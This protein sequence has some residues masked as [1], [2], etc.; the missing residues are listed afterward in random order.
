MHFYV[1]ARLVR[2]VH[3]PPA[4]YRGLTAVFVVLF[5][6]VP[7]AFYLG[8]ALPPHR[9]A[10]LVGA[11]YTWIGVL[12]VLLVLCAT[13]DAVQ[14]VARVVRWVGD[15]KPP[16]DPERRIALARLVGGGIAL[17]GGSATG[18]GL[19]SGLAPV[20]VREVRV[21]LKAF[22]TALRGMT[23]VQ[24]SDM[25]LGP[26]L[27]RR[28]VERVVAQVNALEP[29]VIAITGDLV[30]GS[31]EK[32]REV[33]APLTKL[34]AKHG[35]YFV[36]G[37]HEYYSGAVEWCD[38]LTRIGIRVLRNERVRI[39]SEAAS[40][41][42]AGIDDYHA[43][44]FGHGH[45]ADLGRAL[46]GA[47]PSQAVVLLAHQPIAVHEARERGVGL[48]LSGHTHGGQIWP[49]HFFVRLQQPVVQ[50]LHR[51]GDTQ[52]YVSCGTGCWGPPMRIGA[53]AEITKIVLSAPPA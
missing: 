38:E 1:W 48:V 27:R 47:D 13:T 42:L 11:L 44:E 39:G 46:A 10:I 32:L 53:P 24:L 8:R 35:T 19:V 14:L 4:W 7:A 23:I 40:F 30:D 28:F 21:A 6:S 16:V 41:D 25:H 37:N 34:R 45:G 12:F 49:W 26:T 43:R 15:A 5:C 29:D 17:V 51:F 31:V 36:T 9:G 20:A 50:G 33:V 18:A 3:L 52:I 2:D 22:P